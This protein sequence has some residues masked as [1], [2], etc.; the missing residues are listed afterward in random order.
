[1]N[2]RRPI[3]RLAFALALLPA[4]AAAQGVPTPESVIGFRVGED[5]R[6]ADW[7]QIV[8]YFR[9]LDAASPRVL[10]EDVGQTTEGRPFLVAT[11]TSESNMARLEELRR[12][13]LR[14]ADPR[15]LGEDEARRLL[16]EG[17]TIVSL[18]YGIHST[19]VGAPQ[20]S[21]EE[22]WRL[23]TAN[24]P[25]TLEILDRTVIL[26]IPSHN[27]DGTQKVT[28]WYRKS[29]GTAWEGGAIPF[30]YHRA[31]NSSSP[32]TPPALID[33]AQPGKG[34]WRR[35]VGNAIQSGVLGSRRRELDLAVWRVGHA[36]RSRSVV[37]RHALAEELADRHVLGA[38]SPEIRHGGPH[39]RVVF[40]R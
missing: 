9:A 10:V 29:L 4:L 11:I 2:R 15:G 35:V 27:P 22:A 28:E 3:A 21:M 7:T 25:D 37:R 5:R 6:L 31:G 32:G 14:L 36:L 8:A 24:D 18:N 20:A 40:H 33:M 30:L 12:A 26:M 1:M 38:L 16:A 19:E 23:A 39:A 34:T 17:R 13:N